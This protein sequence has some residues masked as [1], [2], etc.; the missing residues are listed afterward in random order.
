[1]TPFSTGKLQSFCVLLTFYCV[2]MDAMG[3][4]TTIVGRC[5]VKSYTRDELLG[6]RHTVYNQ[7]CATFAAV[8]DSVQAVNRIKTPC[9]RQ[10][11]VF[12]RRRGCRGGKRIKYRRRKCRTP[13]PSIVLANVCSL[14]NKQDELLTNVKYFN[15][16]RNCCAMCFTETHLTPDDPDIAYQLPGFTLIRADRTAASDKLSGGGGVLLF[17]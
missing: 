14:R 9:L 2:T 1:M 5:N 15:E 13:L 10:R 3:D 4:N 16:F 6:L 8:L 7:S 11:C 12:D 17:K